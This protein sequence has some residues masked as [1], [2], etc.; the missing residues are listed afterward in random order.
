MC[1]CFGCAQSVYLESSCT[2]S[3]T[4]QEMDKV[5]D[6]KTLWSLLMPWELGAW[7]YMY[8]KLFGT[9]NHCNV[10]RCSFEA[11]R[12]HV[13]VRDVIWLGTTNIGHELVFEHQ[14]QRTNPNHPMD[15]QEYVRLIEMFRPDVSRCLGVSCYFTWIQPVPIHFQSLRCS[16]VWPRFYHSY[17][18]PT[19]RKWQS[20]LRHYF[21]SVER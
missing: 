8:L 12:R 7:N 13:S 1:R 3:I 9:D 16:L 21:L 6:E 18:L 20:R 14:S 15:R 10:G 5:A 2:H 4:L 17:R 19:R 11:G